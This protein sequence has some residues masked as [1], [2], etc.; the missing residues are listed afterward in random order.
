[1]PAQ[2]NTGI[3]LIGKGSVVPEDSTIG[4]NVVVHPYSEAG[5]FGKRKRSASGADV[6][7][8]MR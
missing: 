3:T 1:M 6:G 8:S 7:K 2:I 5:A 4:R